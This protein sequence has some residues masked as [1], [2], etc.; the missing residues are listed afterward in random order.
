MWNIQ[1]GKPKTFLIFF[2]KKFTTTSKR[3][4]RKLGKPSKFPYDEQYGHHLLIFTLVMVYSTLS[5]F[6]LPFGLIYFVIAMMCSFYNILYVYKTEYEGGGNFWPALVNRIMLGLVIYQLTMI[7]VFSSMEFFPG[8]FVFGL[9]GLTGIF[10]YWLDKHFRPIGSQGAALKLPKESG[11]GPQA[12]KGEYI[13]PE[14]QA[15][16]TEAFEPQDDSLVDVCVANNEGVHE[17]APLL[18]ANK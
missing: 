12:F 13:Q 6:I 10:W 3:D 9:V 7:G 18:V 14:L 4:K 2:K 15:T 17:E 1:H 11:E 16:S 8:G 5:P